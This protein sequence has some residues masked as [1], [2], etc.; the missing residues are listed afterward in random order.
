MVI[1]FLVKLNL[2][3]V[4]E[5]GKNADVNGL[6]RALGGTEDLVVRRNAE[7]AL[8]DLGDKSAI[9]PLIH[10]LKDGDSVIRYEAARALGKIKSARAVVPLIYAL[11]D[12][13]AD[14]RM[15]AI[16]A[17]INIGKSAVE[18]F[19]HALKDE[20]SDVRMGAVAAL[21]EIG[22]KRAVAP[23]IQA[24]KDEDGEVRMRVTEA[25]E[26]LGWVPEE[27]TDRVRYLIAR[28]EWDELEILG[29]PA[30]SLLLQ[31]LKDKDSDLRMGAA[32]AL[33]EIGDARAVEPLI[34][35][36]KDEYW[37]V[38]KRA[39]EALGKMGEPAVDPLIHALG[40]ESWGVRKKA[41]AA[42]GAIV[43]K[44]AVAPLMQVLKD[45]DSVVRMSA[46]EAL[47]RLG[48][49]PKDDLEKANYLIAKKK[50]NELARLGET[51]VAALIPALK[52]EDS[53]VRKGAAGALGE[54]G[55]A[56]AVEP[57]IQG[58]NDKYWDVNKKAATAL[59][60][61]GESAVE[62]LLQTLKAESGVVRWGAVATLGE[63]RDK[64]AV[65]PLV[66]A[67][68]DEYQG[69]NR[70]AEEALGNIGEPAVEP[71]LNVL[72]DEDSNVRKKAA[73]ALGKIGD[74]RAVEPLV[75][76]LKGED[77]G[78]RKKAAAALEKLGWRPGNDT[79][80]VQHLIAN[81]EW[82]LL[83]RMREPAV[84]LLIQALQ[85]KDSDVRTNAASAL[86]KMRDARAAG[87]L[88]HA[89]KDEK[90]L[91]PGLHTAQQAMK[92]ALEEIKKRG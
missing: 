1:L 42:L 2:A 66:R 64:R 67:L 5:M 75:R 10:A 38:N 32:A 60:K 14:V 19:I 23:L 12:K 30:V 44:R 40:N 89:L 45:E 72:K 35:A 43:D 61:I 47:E 39:E 34:R 3:N 29:E 83:V 79:E 26:K 24:L 59:G 8:G 31:A 18:P 69:V 41:A 21:G 46:A 82:D 36:L 57:L 52:D 58:L 85:D 91:Y 65:E 87:P 84:E 92:D 17:L 68:K 63:I 15:S 27:G 56:R 4:E 71:L 28:K 76:A 7:K 55:D 78:V 80:R 54:I 33:G 11:K 86:G 88:L 73:A 74:A 50:W 49:K 25:L 6:I 51:V 22:D 16:E 53:D 9:V 48:W 37:N 81:K 62:P 70:E 77:S 20:D 13:D 90:A